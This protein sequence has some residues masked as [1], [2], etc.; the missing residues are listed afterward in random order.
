MTETSVNTFSILWLTKKSL[1]GQTVNMTKAIGLEML[2]LASNLSTEKKQMLNFVKSFNHPIIGFVTNYETVNTNLD[3][4]LEWKWNIIVIDEVHKLKGG[5]QR[6]PTDVWTNTRLLLE[7]NPQAFRPFLSGTP[8]QNH[9]KDMW[10]YMA[11]FDPQRFLHN[12]E[13]HT[14]AVR[15][16]EVMYA[17]KDL[18]NKLHLTNDKLMDILSGNVIRRT[19]E[20]IGIQ[21]PPVTERDHDLEITSPEL[22]RIHDSITN[23]F[24]LD[25]S[26]MG[27]RP[28]PVTS[29]LAQLHYLRLVLLSP[30]YME[31][32]HYPIDSITF[33]KAL[34]PVR[35]SFSFKGPFPKL[36]YATELAFEILDS[37][38]KVVI[39]SASFNDPIK[40]LEKTFNEVGAK[41]ASITGATTFK[42]SD[43]Q[44]DFLNGDLQVLLLN[45]AAGAEGL[46]LQ[47]S[48]E[49]SGGA[50]QMIEL[51]EW[52]NPGREKQL[53]DRLHRIGT[54]YPVT[55]HH[56]M[57]TNSVDYVI[58]EIIDEK[59]MMAA[60]VMESKALKPREW[61]AKIAAIMKK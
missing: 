9:P 44:D 59:K 54:E 47:R 14:Q 58:R 42:A 1:I 2:P 17:N 12:Y 56:M 15:T 43:I 22:K 57:V 61:A 4:L 6:S 52:W 46:N 41:A 53:H 29:I 21:L 5:A 31:Y 26:H 51:D 27:D 48:K 30:G 24:L 50:S 45:G 20:D 49:W 18:Q 38:E 13:S 19:K 10:A 37:G 11:L 35:R 25:L 7:A 3:D 23:D 16:F 36:D 32:N 55:I 28:V 39:A 60:D 33:E 8:I 40:Y 34:T